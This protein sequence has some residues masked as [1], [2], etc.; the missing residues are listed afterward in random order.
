MTTNSG[1]VPAQSGIDPLVEAL[2]KELIG[3]TAP[4]K[5][6]SRTEDAITA[7]LAEELIASLAPS[8]RTA[9]QASSLE[10][11]ILAAA[12]APALADALAPALAAA[13]T[14]AIIKALNN[15]A[16]SKEAAHPAPKEGSDRRKRE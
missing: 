14:P 12:L 6:G 11:T 10:T 13:L 9:S 4:S 5:G 2:L 16:S 1:R 7:A 3:G 15:L 8:M